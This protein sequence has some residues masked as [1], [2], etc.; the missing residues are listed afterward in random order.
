MC[1]KYVCVECLLLLNAPNIYSLQCERTLRERDMIVWHRHQIKLKT[2]NLFIYLSHHSQ[3]SR[4]HIVREYW[5]RVLDLSGCLDQSLQQLRSA[6]GCACQKQWPTI[7][8]ISISP[9]AS[10]GLQ[11]CMPVRSRR[12]MKWSWR[13]AATL[14]EA[15]PRGMPTKSAMRT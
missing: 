11:Q 14:R 4:F 10:C 15:I 5:P 13:L 9:P 2:L 8:F 6:E 1:G 7:L 12:V 3:P